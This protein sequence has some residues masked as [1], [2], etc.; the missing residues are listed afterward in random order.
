M[1]SS[2]EQY[3]AELRRQLP[4]LQKRYKVA[5]LG[6]FGSYVKGT[7]RADSDLDL[8]VT[9]QE[10][11][12]LFR[13][14]DLQDHLSDLLRVQVDLVVRDSLRPRIGERIRSEVVAV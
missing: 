11:P 3:R 5:T 2:C 14:I 1:N 13:L 7:Q 4:E 12:S 6:L 10:M 9:F 8:L